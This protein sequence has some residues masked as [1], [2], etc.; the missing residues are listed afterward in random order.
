MADAPPDLEDELAALKT[1]FR[2]RMVVYMDDI[3]KALAVLA[4]DCSRAGGLEAVKNIHIPA[5]TLAG[6]SA[7]FGFPAVGDAAR[8]LE[9][10][11]ARRLKDDGDFSPADLEE[12][13]SLTRAIHRIVEESAA[14]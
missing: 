14:D 9:D 11:C 10:F 8:E 5:H 13:E 6:S 12:I 4:A 3:N 7:V 2:E 1:A